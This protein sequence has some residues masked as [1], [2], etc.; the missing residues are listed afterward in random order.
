MG[1][2]VLIMAFLVAVFS[3]AA[4]V[5]SGRSGSQRW[6]TIARSCVISTAA[7]HTVS[8]AAI[9]FAFFTRDFSFNIVAEHVSRDLSVAYALSALYADKSGSMLLWGWLISLFAAVLASRKHN[10]DEQVLAYTLA[11][12]ATTQ[13]FFL[14]MV[15]LVA[16]VFEKNPTPPSDGLGL[17]PLLQ[18]VAMLVHPPTLYVSFAAVSVVFALV[19]AA[20]ITRAPAARWIGWARRWTLFAWCALGLGNLVG[21]WWSYNE[22]GWGGYWAWDPVEN[23]GLMPWILL[24]AFIHSISIR[25]QRN[26]LETWSLMLGIL[27]FAFTL[28][29]P[30]I[31]H[32]GIES[33]L[34]G[35]YGSNFPPYILAAILISFGGALGLLCFRHKDFPKEELP[36]S[37]ASREGAFLITNMLLVILVSVILIGTI[38]P[39]LVELVGGARIAIDRGFFDGVAGPI[40]LVLVFLMGICPLLGWGRTSWQSARR[41]FLYS[42][43][44]TLIIALAVQISGIGKWYTVI[45]IV[46]GFP[47]F[48]IF[49]EWFRGTRARH[50]TRG[51]N[52][53]RAYLSLLGSNRARYGG[54]LVHTGIILIALGVVASSFSGR[55]GTAT[56]D[57]GESMK[58]GEYELTYD[59]LVLREDMSKVS[60][61]ASISVSRNG[62]LIR[63]MYPQNDFWFSRMDTFTE[64]AVRSTPAE[65]L[66][67]SL[68]W[69][70]FDLNDKSV[71]IRAMVNPLVVWIWIGGGFLLLG[72]AIAFST[73]Y[74]R[75]EQMLSE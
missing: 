75:Q 46:C 24:T 26:Y 41:H 65:D 22:L 27:A 21:M 45:T 49:L 25:R 19:I 12:L 17:N 47:L 7:L 4:A 1:R 69:T 55:E 6:V 72:G 56:L 8:L 50:R 3:I 42:L 64:V 14:A 11:I 33:P 73:N 38:L 9:V 28:L 37:L 63:S 16:N 71:T 74:N 39:R 32:G 67:V 13:A 48:N 2:I 61:V 62:R 66:F 53:V 59:E 57:I 34:H 43:A 40:M 29:I 60:A 44:V 31:T 20:L 35:F 70:S 10:Y 58:V 68:A 51:E 52:H 30:F 15:T 36:S 18:N 23:A 54:F 5:V